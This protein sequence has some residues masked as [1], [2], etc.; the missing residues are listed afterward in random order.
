[1][2]VIKPE[3]SLPIVDH[4][5]QQRGLIVDLAA[6]RQGGQ[7][8]GAGGG[9][10]QARENHIAEPAPQIANCAAGP[11]LAAVE[12]DGG[13]VYPAVVGQQLAQAFGLIWMGLGPPMTLDLLK[14][15]HIGMLDGLGDP[16]EIDPA[17]ATT[18]PLRIIRDDQHA[19]A[20]RF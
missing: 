20:G 10:G 3:G 17:I 5:L 2:H 12:V 7:R 8:Q 6:D 16:I 9:D 19:A 11:H 14:G 4:R 15:H 13:P 18:T 1:M